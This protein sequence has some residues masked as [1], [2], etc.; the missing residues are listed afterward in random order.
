MFADMGL[1]VHAITLSIHILKHF[2]LCMYNYNIMCL[3]THTHIHT[4]KQTDWAL[5]V[6]LDMA[7]RD[8]PRQLMKGIGPRLIAVPSYMSVFYVVNE[9]LEWYLLKKRLTN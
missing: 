2:F 4:A 6:M 5:K 8:G 9:E 1:P 3:Y 7:R